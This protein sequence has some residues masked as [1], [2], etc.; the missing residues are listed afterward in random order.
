[1]S[2]FPCW[3]LDES[4]GKIIVRII[5]TRQKAQRPIKIHCPLQ[6]AFELA[7]LIQGGSQITSIMKHEIVTIV[8]LCVTKPGRVI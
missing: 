3:S 5:D 1:M 8:K 6:L 2:S 4:L 7:T